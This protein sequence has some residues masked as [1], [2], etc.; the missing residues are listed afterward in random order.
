VLAWRVSEVGEHE[1]IHYSHSSFVH[2]NTLTEC[3]VVYNTPHAPSLRT[4]LQIALEA[5]GFEVVRVDTYDSVSVEWSSDE[6]TLASTAV[7]VALA[8][9]SA[10]RVSQRHARAHVSAC[11]M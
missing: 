11:A 6:Q 3:P 10:I 7:V 2:T 8:S 5:K 9:P 1:I 4:E